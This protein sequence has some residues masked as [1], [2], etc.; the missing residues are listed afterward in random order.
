MKET[1]R[2]RIEG[3]FGA[4]VIEIPRIPP[5]GDLNSMADS[6]PH[7]FWVLPDCVVMEETDEGPVLSDDDAHA[8]FEVVIRIVDRSGKVISTYGASSEDE[9]P[10]AIG[11]AYWDMVRYAE[12][13]KDSVPL[14]TDYYLEQYVPGGRWVRLHGT[15]AA[16][17]GE[18]VWQGIQA[19]RITFDDVA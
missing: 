11:E 14:F 9:V 16:G 13:R 19:G 6:Y 4:G 18:A 7:T 15:M 1:A 8:L 2:Y 12:K 5:D 10:Q 17:I 3:P